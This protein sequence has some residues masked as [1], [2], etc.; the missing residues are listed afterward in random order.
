MTNAHVCEMQSIR[1]GRANQHHV[2]TQHDD[3]WTLDYKS[4]IESSCYYNMYAGYQI[5]TVDWQTPRSYSSSEQGSK[6]QFHIVDFISTC[7]E[8]S[9]SIPHYDYSCE[10]IALGPLDGVRDHTTYNNQPRLVNDK[11]K[12]HHRRLNT[13]LTT[14]YEIADTT[15]VFTEGYWRRSYFQMRCEEVMMVQDPILV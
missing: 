10:E 1:H 11:K 6:T 4:S 7:D 3:N 9:V 12:V 14:S 5:Y 2:Q 8:R 15:H 13:N